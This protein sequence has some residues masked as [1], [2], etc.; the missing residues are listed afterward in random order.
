[1]GAPKELHGVTVG[2]TVPKPPVHH[3]GGGQ[4]WMGAHLC[5]VFDRVSGGRVCSQD[6]VTFITKPAQQ[7]PLL[8]CLVLGWLPGHGAESSHLEKRKK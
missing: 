1:M 4:Q 8:S 7:H 5:L 3:P 6:C 2:A